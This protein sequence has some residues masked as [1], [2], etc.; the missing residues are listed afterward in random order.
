MPPL[1]MFSFK[2]VKDTAK[3]SAFAEGRGY[4]GER[5]KH[6]GKA[7]QRVPDNKIT[8]TIGALSSKT[9]TADG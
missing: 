7:S 4:V 8:L 1:R 5:T 2:F 9:E 6:P 3:I